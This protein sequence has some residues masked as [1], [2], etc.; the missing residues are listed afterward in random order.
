MRVELFASEHQ[1]FMQVFCSKHMNNAFCFFWKAKGLAYAN[2]LF[3]L[4]ASLLT[5]IAYEGGRAVLRT[6]DWGCC[7]EQ[8]YWRQLPD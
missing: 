7:C 3:S 5:Q 4:L 1:H 8:T 2:P 6:P